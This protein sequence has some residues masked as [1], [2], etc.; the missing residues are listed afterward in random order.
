[1]LVLN[2]VL[3]RL[4]IL[5][6]QFFNGSFVE[7]VDNINDTVEGCLFPDLNPLDPTILEY[8]SH[9]TRVKCKKMQPYL[10]FIDADG[11]LQYNETEYEKYSKE[12]NYTNIKCVYKTFDRSLGQDD[13][14][15]SYAT[16]QKLTRP[17]KLTRDMVEV[18][19]TAEN[20]KGKKDDK[21]YYNLHAHPAARDK[22]VFA[23]P[24]KDELS[25]LLMT[26]DSVA[27]SVLKRNMPL[28]YDYVTN[29]MGMFMFQRK[30]V[31]LL[32]IA[33]TLHDKNMSFQITSYT[34]HYYMT[35]TR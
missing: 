17:V 24:G 1:M 20:A 35:S 13:N 14:D 26:I 31:N 6:L 8:I 18:S 3:H 9:P 2:S 27:L 21:F 29:N 28:T 15:W 16:E 19:C 12:K 10:T 5:Q 4:D 32:C 23:K 30:L 25:V 22:S 7:I 33:A 34:V 11:Y